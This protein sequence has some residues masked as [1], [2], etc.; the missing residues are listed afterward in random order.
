[1]TIIEA[2]DIL[3]QRLSFKLQGAN[4]TSGRF[5]EDSHPIVTTSNIKSSQEVIDISDNDFNV[6]LNGFETGNVFKVLADCTDKDILRDDLLTEF[7]SLFDNAISYGMAIR[8]IE[9]IISSVRSNRNKRINEETINKIHFDLNG[10]YG[11][12]YNPK[13]P[14]QQGIASKYAL[15]IERIQKFI[16]GQRKLVSVTTG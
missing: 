10:N 15:E 5:Y 6:F 11:R 12:N 7:P 16:G 2:K 1:M 8:T 4:P 14:K 13:Y 9:L 3:I